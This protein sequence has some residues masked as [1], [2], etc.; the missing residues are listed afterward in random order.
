MVSAKRGVP[1]PATANRATRTPRA[2]N[3][4]IGEVKADFGKRDFS[5]LQTGNNLPQGADSYERPRDLRCR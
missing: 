2:R 4:K 1:L 5:K 3:A